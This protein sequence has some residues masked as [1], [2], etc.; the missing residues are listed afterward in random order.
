[1]SEQ[2]QRPP[3]PFSATSIYDLLCRRYVQRSD[4]RQKAIGLVYMTAET[5]DLAETIAS[6]IRHIG[7]KTR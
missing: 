1:M 5:H 6:Y 2:E 7:E 3:E 4:P